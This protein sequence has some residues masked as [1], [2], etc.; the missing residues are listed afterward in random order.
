M[1]FETAGTGTGR[2]SRGTSARIAG[3]L[4]GSTLFMLGASGVLAAQT[5]SAEVAPSTPAG[6]DDGELTRIDETA[7][8]Y[9]RVA[10][11]QGT[12]AFDQEGV[13]PNDE[14]FNIFGTTLTSMCSKPNP[15]LIPTEG[16]VAN[17]YVNVGGDIKKAFTADVREMAQDA[18]EQTLMACSCATGGA[19]GQAMVMGVPLSAVVEMAELEEGVNTVTAYGTDG[20]GTPIPLRYALDHN[21]LLVYQVNGEDI[22]DAVG[23]SLQL[24]IPQTVAR[25]FTRNIVDIEFTACDVEPEVLEVSPEYRNKVNIMNHADG[26]VFMAGNE[27]TFSGVAD[28]LGSPIEAI[29]FSFDGGET[30]TVCKTAGATADKW[31]NWDFTTSFDEAGDYRMTV[32]A[33]TAD[34]VVSP[35][36]ATLTFQVI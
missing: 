21:A 34:G 31:V 7:N 26:C 36:E 14:L 15:E 16:G 12:F 10:D 30:W 9:T 1:S 20:F 25:Y 22:E 17:Y 29:E 32:R 2:R 18:R 19:L 11:V 27:I 33:R 23:T 3:G 5:A 28:D 13:S 4:L 8:Q 24:W 6:G 35:L